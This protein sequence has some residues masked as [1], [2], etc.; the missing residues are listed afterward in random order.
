MKAKVVQ[1]ALFSRSRTRHSLCHPRGCLSHFS[2]NNTPKRG[3]R[4]HRLQKK[5]EIRVCFMGFNALHP[6]NKKNQLCA[7]R[8]VTRR[9]LGVVF[10]SWPDPMPLSLCCSSKGRERGL[11]FPQP[12]LG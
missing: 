3:L 10:N 2:L 7:G 4:S 6:L 9:C 12:S 1:R 11:C 5:G 8:D